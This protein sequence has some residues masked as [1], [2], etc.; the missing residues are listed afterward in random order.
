MNKLIATTAL[1]ML[2]GSLPLA[3]Q[4]VMS[5]DERTALRTEIRAYLLENPEVLMEAIAVLEERRS[6]QEAASEETMLQVNAEDIFNDPASWVGGNP[7]GDITIVEFM[8][9]R[10][11]YCKKAF[12]EVSELLASDGN[13][14]FIVKEFP[15]LGE[16]SDLASR[17]AVSVL[18]LEGSETYGKVH[19][20][21]MTHRG[22]FTP[23]VLNRFAAEYGFADTAAVMA[24]MSSAE[25]SAVIEANH[26]LGSRLQINGTPTF[27]IQDTM[28][29]GYV[30]LDGL[31]QVVAAERKD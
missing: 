30:P 24:R 16:Q 23:E 21:L 8:D 6:T 1:A 5:A 27:V 25:V 11:G 26:A 10:C 31:R 22:D 18:Q 17:F 3:A 28:L 4:S 29:R 12:A 20:A 13:I 19:D 9:Y 14:R 2:M 7:E 15:I